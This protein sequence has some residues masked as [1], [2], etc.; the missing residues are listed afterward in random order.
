MNP[1][2]RKNKRNEA[3]VDVDYYCIGCK[4]GKSADSNRNKNFKGKIRKTSTGF[5]YVCKGLTQHLLHRNY[6]ACLSHYKTMGLLSSDANKVDFATS[7]RYPPIIDDSVKHRKVSSYTTKQIGLTLT[8]NGPTSIQVSTNRSNKNEINSQRNKQ[9]MYN[10]FPSELPRQLLK[11]IEGDIAEP[12]SQHKITDIYNN[13]KKDKG[14]NT[15]DS[16]IATNDDLDNDSLTNAKIERKNYKSEGTNSCESEM[17][18]DMDTD[19]NDD[20]ASSEESYYEKKLPYNNESCTSTDT[21]LMLNQEF[22]SSDESTIDTHINNTTDNLTNDN[23]L[24]IK[25]FVPL[26][27]ASPQLASEITL[28]NILTKYKMP[29]N[30]LKTIFDWAKTCQ[31]RKGFDFCKVKSCR[32][33]ETIFEDIHNRL[34]LPLTDKFEPQLID[35]LPD[36]KPATVYHRPFMNALQSLLSNHSIV[37]EENLSFPDKNSPFSPVDMSENSTPLIEELHHGEW[38]SRTWEKKC[39]PGSKEI[40]VPIILY[41]DGISL[42]A[43]GRLT[44]TPL[45]MTLGIFN[46][47]TRSKR[48]DAWETIYWH[49]D[50]NFLS[51]NHSNTPS[52]EDN[53]QNLHNGLEVALRSFKDVCEQKGG[54]LWDGL[55]YGGKIWNGVKMKFAIAYVVGDTEQHDRLCGRYIC[56]NGAVSK[57]CRHCNIDTVDACFPRKQHLTRLWTPS[58]FICTAIRTTTGTDYG[59][60]VSHHPIR[61]AFH[62]LDFG[63]NDNNIHMATPGECL[64]M[65]QLG[66]AKRAVESI[67]DF[68]FGRNN[69]VLDGVTKVRANR[70]EALESLTELTR[71]YGAKLTRQ[72]D[73]DFPRTKFTSNILQATKKEGSDYAGI[74]LS[75]IVTLSSDEGKEILTSKAAITNDKI[76]KLIY[77]LELVLGMEEFLKHG[78]IT[79]DEI[80]KLKKMIDHFLT[81]INENLKRNKGMGTNLIK[82]HLYFHVPLYIKLWGPPA[83]WDSAP[84]ESNH[85]TE[86]KAPSRNTQRNTSTFIEQTGNQIIEKRLIER[87]IDMFGL[88][89]RENPHIPCSDK[90]G[91]SKFR[92]KRDI[93][94]EPI[95][96]W[97]KKENKVKSHHN[98]EVLHFCCE[99]VLPLLTTNHVNGFTEHYRIGGENNTQYLFRSNPSFMSAGGQLCNVWY[100]WALFDVDG[101]DNE[102]IPAQIICLLNITT[103][104]IPQEGWGEMDGKPDCADGYPVRSN[105]QYAIV[106]K[107]KT[108]AK[109]RHANDKTNIVWTGKIDDKLYLYPC[110]SI[111][112]EIAVVQNTSI[113][114]SSDNFFVIRNRND[115]LCNFQRQIHNC[116]I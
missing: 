115:W 81:Q 54:V 35:W 9:L 3:P 4:L 64:H 27:R 69:I 49:P 86:I 8:A 116:R 43:H 39:K 82:N 7:L 87:A 12:N 65:H 52:S 26:S 73:R 61:N 74:L 15:D 63:C 72:S 6:A 91:G 78:R 100:D 21:N 114:G 31:N 103:L 104:N 90:V 93:N 111:N 71:N 105:S 16:D 70:A 36:L 56:Y 99:Q 41:M 98:K 75:L 62:K 84:S 57:I 33:R 106:R 22:S 55:P 42:D 45:N 25:Q 92:I 66:V 29:M 80:P 20:D 38:W 30:A 85:K 17:Y 5:S 32:R 96:E 24:R 107:F 59:K 94:N 102:G 112:R 19:N 101:E 13:K 108:E 47:A 46:V 11:E 89:D 79:R 51:A 23:T 88:E 67:S 44:L 50:K 18:T 40:L 2:K 97:E 10:P 68:V 83:G 53:I 77:T 14:V 48:P 113:N 95:M 1:K 76:D 37:K 60:S 110:D 58:D 34:Q 109:K 28:M